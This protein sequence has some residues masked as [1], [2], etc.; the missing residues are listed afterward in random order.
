MPSPSD[1]RPT[2]TRQGDT[3]D[4]PLDPERLRLEAN[5]AKARADATALLLAWQVMRIGSTRF[6]LAINP[7]P[8]T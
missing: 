8:L 1:P 5:A 7:N 2:H 3:P 6:G 4:P